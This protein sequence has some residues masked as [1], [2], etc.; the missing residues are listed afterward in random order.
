[1]AMK[2]PRQLTGTLHIT[3]MGDLGLLH[4]LR[5]KDSYWHLEVEPERV[6]WLDGLKVKVEGESK[7]ILVRVTSIVQA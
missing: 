2:K 1:M 7:G 4:V 5:T 3:S 6:R